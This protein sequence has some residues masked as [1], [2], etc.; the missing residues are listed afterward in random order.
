[1]SSSLRG[2]HV[3]RRK[4]TRKKPVVRI[5]PPKTVTIPMNMHI[6][7]PATPVVKVGDLV[8]VGT[9]IGEAA[10]GV[11][12]NIHSSVSGK[13]VKIAE[14]LAYDGNN[15]TAIII[16]S[17][18]EMTP[19]ENI[20]PPVVTDKESFVAALKAAGIVGLGGAGFPTHVKFDVDPDRI[21]YLVI[22]G[23]ECEPY[24]TSDTITMVERA[25]D[26]ARG[27]DALAQHMGVRQVII[28]IENNKKEAISV[29]KEMAAAITSCSVRV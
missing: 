26:M 19:D 17:D 16:E 13:V 10:A 7:R 2:V 27:I 5:E 6:G 20:A 22:N 28:G 4:S 14:Q 11:S 23:A 12:A 9:L 15:T 18:G 3:P 1:M 21:E 29:M 25:A 24:V 8:K